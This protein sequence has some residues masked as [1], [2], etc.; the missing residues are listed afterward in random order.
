MNPS[1]SSLDLPRIMRESEIPSAREPL[2]TLHAFV[3]LPEREIRVELTLNS[4]G[5]PG[6]GATEIDG[7][8]CRAARAGGREGG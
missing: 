1:V 6:G 7:A 2:L 5:P 8:G 4:P 3:H